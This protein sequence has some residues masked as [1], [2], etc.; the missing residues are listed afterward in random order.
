M[1]LLLCSEPITSGPGDNYLSSP[2]AWGAGCAALDW[3]VAP[4]GNMAHAPQA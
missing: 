1:R 2:G 4:Q 3:P